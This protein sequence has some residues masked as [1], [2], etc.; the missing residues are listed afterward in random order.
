MSERAYKLGALAP[1]VPYGLRDLA[2]YST[3]VLPRPAAAVKPPNVVTWG[4]AL[5]NTIGDCTIAGVYHLLKAWNTEVSEDTPLPDT[6]QI[7]STYFGL[8][9]GGDT[10][11]VEV[12][13]LNT[14]YSKGLFGNRIAGWVP[15]NP[16]NLEH[17]HLAIELYGAA[18]V[19]VALPQSAETQTDENRAWT[20]VPTSPIL[21]GHC[22]VYVGYDEYALYAVTWGELVQ[23]TYPWWATYGTE[24]ACV[25]PREFVEAGRG[26]TLNLATLQADLNKLKAVG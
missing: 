9:G 12:T 8:T 13:V 22:I 3:A 17:L 11:L 26:P 2:S 25:L 14:W 1:R 7:K 4:M 24:A 21:G 18:Y 15:L 16:R 19:G 5:N 10:G 23:V 20:V 6:A